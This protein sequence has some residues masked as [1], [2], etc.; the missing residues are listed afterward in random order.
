MPTQ[1]ITVAFFRVDTDI[2]VWRGS[3]TLQGYDASFNF[4]DF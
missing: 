1:V 2:G 3:Q 4:I